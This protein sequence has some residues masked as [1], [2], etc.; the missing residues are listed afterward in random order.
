MDLYDLEL[1]DPVLDARNAS[2]GLRRLIDT[3]ITYR[4]S[5]LGTT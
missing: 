1:Q 4:R 3:L 5:S 2:T